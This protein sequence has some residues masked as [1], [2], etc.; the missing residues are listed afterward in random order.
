MRITELLLINPKISIVIIAFL[1]TLIMTVVTKKFTDQKRMKELKDKQKEL[2]RTL[3]DHKGD[4]KK[5]GDINKEL[6]ESSMELMK[7]SFK[8]MLFTFIPLLIFFYWIRGLYSPILSS[9][10]WW[11]LG[12]GLISSIAL[13]KA[14]KVV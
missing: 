14:L 10:F 8:P 1:I 7:H 4:M 6:M 5:M 9:W 3:K 2:Q 13:R 12:A 11:Y